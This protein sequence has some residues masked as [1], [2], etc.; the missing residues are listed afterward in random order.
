MKNKLL[1]FASLLVSIVS[2]RADDILVKWERN[3]LGLNIGYKVYHANWAFTSWKL[4]GT[5]TNLFSTEFVYHDAQPG[6]HYFTITSFDAYGNESDGTPLL[7]VN[8]P[9]VRILTPINAKATLIPS[10]RFPYLP[11]ITQ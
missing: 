2:I 6:I 8:I 11:V 4:V 5:I 9:F 10:R 7:T 3:T 1:L